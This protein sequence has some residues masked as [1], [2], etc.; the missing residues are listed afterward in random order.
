VPRRRSKQPL[1]D[2]PAGARQSA[3]RALARREHSA[4][5]LHYKLKSCGVP[6]PLA[7]EVIEDFSARGWQSD[8]RYAESL[9]R[10]R[11][12]HC[13]GPLRIEAE[14]SA[15]GLSNALIREA[16]AAAECDWNDLALQAYQRRFDSAPA[17]T[18][19]GQKCYR[20]LAQRGFSSEQIRTVLRNVPE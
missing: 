5:E 6:E 2:T 7:G 18:A 16:M 1:V 20:F 19:E 11:I 17:G 3:L 15:A 8:Q 9:L 12:A 14:L 13:Y 4:R 10:T